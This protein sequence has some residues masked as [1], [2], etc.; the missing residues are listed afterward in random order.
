MKKEL[1]FNHLENCFKS[2]MDSHYEF[3]A[4]QVEM[5]G[6][7]ELELIINRIGNAEDKLEYYRNAYNHD[8]THKHAGDKIRIVGFTF[9]DSIAEIGKDLF[10]EDYID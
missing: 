5:E 9:A 6:Y 3:V 2:A 8:L 7:P 10:D 4:I 1:N